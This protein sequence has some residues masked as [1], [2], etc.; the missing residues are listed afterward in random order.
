MTGSVDKSYREEILKVA[1]YDRMANINVRIWEPDSYDR[2]LM[3][4]AGYMGNGG[5]FAVIAQTMA[6][7]GF[8]VVAPDM[9]G[10]GKS[11]Y[12]GDLRYYKLNSYMR[13]LRA[14]RSKIVGPEFSMIATSAGGLHALYLYKSDGVTPD[15]IVLNDVPMVIDERVTEISFRIAE[16]I[17]QVF[18]TEEEAIE[19]FKATRSDMTFVSDEIHTEFAR[20]RMVPTEHGYR[21][22][23]DPV[24]AGHQSQSAGRRYEMANLLTGPVGGILLMYGSASNFADLE[25]AL[26]IQSKVPNL[27]VRADFESG[28]P[29]SLT[30]PQ[31]VNAVTEFLL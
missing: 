24:I 16:E 30:C 17:Q 31:E 26:D 9:I 5:D 14:V 6:R 2:T 8:R 12:F 29:L 25:F 19:R 28:H 11:T 13:C 15:K 20:N 27:T 23:I 22:A 4:V 18:R 3:C 21:Y 7:H 10:R 1:V